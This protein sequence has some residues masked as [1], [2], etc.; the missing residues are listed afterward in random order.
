MLKLLTDF[1][2]N[3][4]QRAVFN[5]Q[6]FSRANIQRLDPLKFYSRFPFFLIYINNSYSNLQRNP[7]LF[8]NDTSLFS[9]VTKS[10]TTTNNANNVN[11]DSEEI[12][13]WVFQWKLS[14]NPNLSKQA[15]EVIFSRK[16][17]RLVILNYFSV[18]FLS[19]EFIFRNI[20]GLC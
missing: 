4:K 18:M 6:C 16:T 17:T 2:N 15:Q 9:T 3:R 7:N 12:S 20:C 11:S 13:E 19:P 1:L 8:A 10:E 14:F 5:E